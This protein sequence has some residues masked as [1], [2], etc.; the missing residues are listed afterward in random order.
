MTPGATKKAWVDA[1]N[2]EKVSLQSWVSC[3]EMGRILVNPPSFLRVQK[4]SFT[5]CVLG[6]PKI[7]P[8]ALPCSLGYLD[9]R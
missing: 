5:K 2:P 3:E 7:I 9:L 6:T 1:H 4:T 8:Y